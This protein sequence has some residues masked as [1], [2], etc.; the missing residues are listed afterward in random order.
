MFSA[1]L[2]T[3]L[4]R[5][6]L[7]ALALVLTA[8]GVMAA[9]ASSCL[10]EDPPE[11]AA[12]RANCDIEAEC[13]LRTLEACQAASCD[14]Q[15]G[16]PLFTAPDACL[17]NAENCLEAAACACDGG[18][19]KLDECSEGGSDPT[20]VGTCDTLVEQEPESTYREQ[21]CRL[22]SSCEDIAVCGAVGG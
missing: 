22:E 1:N 4:P 8:L 18:C 10:D 6:G 21:R 15:T 14:P 19:A 17:A 16:D 11:P 9:D 5:R 7:R 13:D 12:C 3:N 20:C 2:H